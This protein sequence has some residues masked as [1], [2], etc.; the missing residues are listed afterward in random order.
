MALTPAAS[1]AATDDQKKF[2]YDIVEKNTQTLNDVGAP[3][4][5]ITHGREDAI[6]YWANK[7]GFKARP[8]DIAGYDDEGD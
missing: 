3:E 1:R 8:L 5:W 4:V 2:A 6:V 7:N